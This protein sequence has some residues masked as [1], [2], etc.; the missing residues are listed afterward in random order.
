MEKTFVEANIYK[1][2]HGED[3]FL[4]EKICFRVED[5][6][7]IVIFHSTGRKK[8]NIVAVYEVSIESKNEKGEVEKTVFEDVSMTNIVK[9]FVYKNAGSLFELVTTV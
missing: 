7:K 4:K 9:D 2:T 5:I 8:T 3:I 1:F 6:V